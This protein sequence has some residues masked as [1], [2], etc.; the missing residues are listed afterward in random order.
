MAEEL[1]RTMG[2]HN[3]KTLLQVNH[4]GEWIDGGKFPP[5]LGLFATIPKAKRGAPLDKTKYFYLDVVHMEIAFWDCLS[6][7]GFK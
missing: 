5:L 6:V 4:N 1:H 2:C 7:G 3:Y